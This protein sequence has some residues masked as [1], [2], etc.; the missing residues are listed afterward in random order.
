MKVTE[1]GAER[2]AEAHI[3][4]EGRVKALEEYGQYV[5]SHD[6]AICCYIPVE[7]GHAIRVESRF[8]GTVRHV[9]MLHLL[10]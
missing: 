7:E 3:Y 1:K 2:T 4:V 10:S 8:S 6:K 9:L 5:D